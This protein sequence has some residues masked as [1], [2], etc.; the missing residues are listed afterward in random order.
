MR[1]II[2][3]SKIFLYIL[4]TIISWYVGSKVSHVKFLTLIHNL[5]VISIFKFDAELFGNIKLH[6]IMVEV[7]KL[8]LFEILKIP[9]RKRKS[10]VCRICW[11][12]TIIYLWRSEY[13][14]RE[15]FFPFHHI[16]SGNRTEIIRFCFCFLASLVLFYFI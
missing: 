13:N 1:Q 2:N 6:S 5:F 15:S 12:M 7:V 8:L 16:G 3:I 11:Y 14:L 10:L 4:I 9:K